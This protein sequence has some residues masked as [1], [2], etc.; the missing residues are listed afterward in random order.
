M[1]HRLRSACSKLLEALKYS[2]VEVECDEPGTA[3]EEIVGQCGGEL[4]PS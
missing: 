1:R 4:L 2:G 3:T